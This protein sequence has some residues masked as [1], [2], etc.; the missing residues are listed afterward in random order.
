MANPSFCIRS[1]EYSGLMFS[2][3]CM[4]MLDVWSRSGK[5]KD[6]GLVGGCGDMGAS[7]ASERKR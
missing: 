2:V 7:S 3:H 6:V 5:G 1:R 4:A